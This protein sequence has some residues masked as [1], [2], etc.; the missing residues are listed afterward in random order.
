MCAVE[1][2]KG[3]FVLAV[4]S[5]EKPDRVVV[6]REGSPLM[7]GIAD[8]GHYAASDASGLLSV[9][10][11]MMYLENGD[12]ARLTRESIASFDRLGQSAQRKVITSSLSANAVGWVISAATCRLPVSTATARACQTLTSWSYLFLNPVKPPIPL[13]HFTTPEPILTT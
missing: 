3:A 8:D 6:A 9:T 2:L 10:K 5:E 1:H 4:I 12:V 7:P 11:R 13:T